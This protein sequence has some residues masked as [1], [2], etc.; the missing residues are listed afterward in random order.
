[1]CAAKVHIV[2]GCA[3][4]GD[5]RPNPVRWEIGVLPGDVI[6]VKYQ[7][8]RLLGEGGMGAVYEARHTGTGRR[9]AVKVIHGEAMRKNGDL[10]ARFQ[11]EARAAGAIESRHIA[12][13]LDTGVDAAT[14]NPYLVM[15]FLDGHD[16]QHTIGK[17][18]AIEPALALRIVAQACIGL[19]K[20]HE[21]GVVHRDLKPANIFLTTQDGGEILV[22]LLDFGIAKVAMDQATN[23]EQAS[24]TITG[25]MLGSPL[26]MSPEQ[27][28]GAKSVDHRTDI[29]SLGVVLYEALCGKT[30]YGHC[31]T[32]GALIIA[33]ASERP[34]PVQEHAP[35]I[36][37]EVASIVHRALVHEVDGRFQS[38]AAMLA[39]IRPL[40]GQGTY[41]HESMFQPLSPHART[42]EAARLPPASLPNAA[43]AAAPSA[44]SLPSLEAP[45]AG[46][47]APGMAT[48][49]A[50]GPRSTGRAPLV[51]AI[52]A[53]LV[54]GGGGYAAYR[55]IPHKQAAPSVAGVPIAPS[56]VVASSLPPPPSASAPASA[57]PLTVNLAV[58]PPTASVDVDGTPAAVSAGQVALSGSPGT[59][60]HVRVYL[61]KKETRADVVVSGSGPVPSRIDLGV[62]AAGLGKSATEPVPPAAA[63][64]APA[65][66][67][68]PKPAPAGSSLDR[69]FQ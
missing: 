25:S 30:P 23:V 20:A 57:A 15:E 42:M 64:P 6:D 45:A 69:D 49:H 7:I 21:A 37:P 32:I 27:T 22:K 13:V 39:A 59:V 1:V 66:S 58:T 34:R 16:L 28:K 2:T 52:A 44:S 54:L 63:R 31:D 40:L 3:P 11:R 14:G 9:V 4:L 68:S 35:W 60:H 33:I 5:P 55:L 46:I 19:Q 56:T 10:V 12:H 50:R 17:M 51:V 62:P 47:T 24:L 65:P 67:P 48:S 41:L 43:P 29:W 53:S 36:P 18:G 61:G 38:A 8:T 26:Y